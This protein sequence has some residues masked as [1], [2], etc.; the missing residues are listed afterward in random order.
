MKNLFLIC[1][2]FFFSFINS[3]NIKSLVVSYEEIY[4]S[5]NNKGDVYAHA[6]LFHNLDESVYAVGGREIESNIKEE[7]TTQTS[8]KKTIPI[9][10]YF[11]KYSS[12]KITKQFGNDNTISLMYNL[13]DFK[14]S[15]LQEEKTISGLLC[16]KAVAKTK[17]REIIA[18]YTEKLGVKGGPRKYDGL[19]GLIMYLENKY[20]IYRVIKIEKKL[21]KINLPLKDKNTRIVTEALLKK[22]VTTTKTISNNKKH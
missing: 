12:N 14:W 20:F 7:T 10:L 1:S 5:G 17:E 4:I 22:G 3:Q 8:T 13:N 16:K 15:L 18:W 11:K 6:K 21:K 2:I 19:P 9:Q